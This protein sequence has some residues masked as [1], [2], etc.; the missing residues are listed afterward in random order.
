MIEG[1]F[2]YVGLA[3]ND[4]VPTITTE[5]LILRLYAEE[6]VDNVLEYLHRQHEHFQP[7]FPGG[8]MN[9]TRDTVVSA[10]SRKHEMAREDRGYEFNLFLRTEPTR[11]AG[12]CSVA[13]VKRGDLQ[14]AF[15]GYALA[16]EFQ[17][18]GL[19]TEAVRASI[20]FAFADLDLHRLEGSYMEDNIKSAAI[21]ASCGFLQE[22]VFK[23]YQLLGGRWQDRIVTSLLNP[24]WRGTGR[25]V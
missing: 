10:I 24:A 6:D 22:G 11:V 9:L 7:W 21:L 15:I 19:M 14:Q 3:W 25:V 1:G 23:D 16:A 20:K 17:G 5:R 13:D 18:Q 4:G 2:S 8:T 12:Q